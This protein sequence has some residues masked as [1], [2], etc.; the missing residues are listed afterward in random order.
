[1][2]TRQRYEAAPDFTEYLATVEKNVDLWHSLYDRARIPDETLERV[3]ELGGRWHLLVL[4]EDWCGDAVNIVPVVAKLADIAGNVEVRI[5]GRDANPDIMDAYL[6]GASRS[7]PVVIVLD[8][9]YR[10]CGSWGPRPGELQA[11]V[12]GPG[13]ALP[14]VERYREI[15]RWYARDRGDTILKEFV[16][17]FA[18]C[19][20]LATN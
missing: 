7:I 3:H 12:L 20:L 8:A 18:R 13:Q 15:R 17:K 4:S 6:T 9:E 14:K 1:M 2:I 16:E 10:E 11:W 5:L 19:V